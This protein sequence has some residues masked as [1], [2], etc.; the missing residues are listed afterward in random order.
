[1]KGIEL[2]VNVLVI[3]VIAVIV[4]VALVALLTGGLPFLTPINYNAAL[5]SSCGT[6]VASNLCGVEGS[7]GTTLVNV[8]VGGDGKIDSA[9]TLQA[10]CD[11]K[12]QTGG[13]E[14]KCK[15]LCHC[16]GL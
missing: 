10:L 15:Q 6:L 3:I 7:T 5:Q 12:F 9:D 11:A 16:P 2:P 8:D 13:S 1:M 4:I 14:T